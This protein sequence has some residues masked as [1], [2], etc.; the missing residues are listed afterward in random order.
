MAQF[1][2]EAINH[3]RKITNVVTLPLKLKCKS[4]DFLGE[5]ITFMKT[6]KIASLGPLSL[7]DIINT[8]LKEQE[9]L[10]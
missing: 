9:T 8:F 6:D 2:N 7:G 1:I 4:Y 5:G 3:I 10:K